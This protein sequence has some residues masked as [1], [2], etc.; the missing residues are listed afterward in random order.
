MVMLALFQKECGYPRTKKQKM[1]MTFT[2]CPVRKPGYAMPFGVSAVALILDR[3]FINSYLYK[4][5]VPKSTV[6]VAD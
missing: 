3:N 5:T 2:F 1:N 6:P 4:K